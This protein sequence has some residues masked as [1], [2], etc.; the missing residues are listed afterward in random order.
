M[1]TKMKFYV[2]TVLVSIA[3]T[4]PAIAGQIG[5]GGVKRIV[6]NGTIN[7]NPSYLI[8]CESGSDRIVIRKD[9]KWAD[10]VGG[11]FSDRLWKLDTEA[12]SEEMCK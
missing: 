4:F 3:L 1:E 8:V 7:G 9:N 2:S 5:S 10:S 12:F 11:T 6:D